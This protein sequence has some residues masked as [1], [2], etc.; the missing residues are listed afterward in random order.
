MAC[1]QGTDHHH[2]CTKADALGNV[3]VVTDAAVGDD[4]F[5]GHAGAPFDG[6]ELPA[7]GAK[8]GFEF[9]NADFA[10]ADADLGGVSAPVFQVNHR[11]GRGHVAGDDEGGGHLA[12]EVDDHVAH[13]VSMAV[14]D[15]NGHVLRC[16]TQF[17]QRDHGGIVRL[18]DTQGDRGIQALGLHV[19]NKL[20]VVQVKAVHHIKVAVLRQP[21]ADGLIHHRLHIG[22][23]DGQAEFASTEFHTGITFRAA[24]HAALAGQQQNI[25][26]VKN[27]HGPS[28]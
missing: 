9:G 3:A 2:G 28:S 22:R 13:A 25:V 12:F 19:F 21:D 4:G 20:D 14:G 27:F 5:G 23:H 17:G 26:V 11:F 10:R 1:K 8:A 24:V 7:T 6:R 18:F 15:V 16:Q